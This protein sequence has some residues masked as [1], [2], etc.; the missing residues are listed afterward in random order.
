MYNT[1]AIHLIV[2]YYRCDQESRQ[3]EIDDCLR[4]NL[5]NSY[6]TKVHLL[7]EEEYDFQQ[8]PNKGKITQTVIKERLT[9]ER[10]FQYANQYAN[11]VFWILSNADI[12]FDQS[13]KYLQGVDLEKRLFAL[14]RHNVLRDGTI[15]LLNPEFAHG[16]QDA[17]IFKNPVPLD[18]IN[19]GFRLGVPGCDNRIAY[20]L[21]KAGYSISNPSMKIIIRHLDLARG[22]D[23]A[24]R[25]LEYQCMNT[26][27]NIR[28]GKIAAPP[29]QFYIYPTDQLDEISKM[30]LEAKE[31]TFIL[32]S[33]IS[34]IIRILLNKCHFKRSA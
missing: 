18:K 24:E 34:K 26:Q 12:Y 15:E 7:T 22:K 6:I 8:F 1:G 29:Y 20:E 27:E 4:N 10:A 32:K 25:G 3:K 19:T 23:T 2:Q 5:Q 31:R 14:T 11:S 13:L 9:F 28:S 17:W 21:I 16:S 33:H 30:P